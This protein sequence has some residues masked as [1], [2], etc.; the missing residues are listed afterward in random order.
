MS[1]PGTVAVTLDGGAPLG[2]F[3]PAGAMTLRGPDGE[4]VAA[5]VYFPADGAGGLGRLAGRLAD[6]FRARR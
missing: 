6:E 2:E 1:A 5:R 3:R 4:D